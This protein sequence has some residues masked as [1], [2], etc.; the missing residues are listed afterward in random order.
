MVLRISSSSRG[1]W[2][3]S[4]W[5]VSSTVRLFLSKGLLLNCVTALAYE[6]VVGN[7]ESRNYSDTTRDRRMRITNFI[8][9]T[10]SDDGVVGGLK[11]GPSVVALWSGRLRSDVL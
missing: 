9:T 8:D 6:G 1:V 3:P 10:M 5:A 2:S 11:G 7:K 4:Q